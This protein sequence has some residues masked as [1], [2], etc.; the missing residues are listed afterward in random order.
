MDRYIFIRN[1]SIVHWISQR[2]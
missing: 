1:W 2:N